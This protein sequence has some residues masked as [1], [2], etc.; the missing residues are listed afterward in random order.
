[1][2]RFNGAL[3]M[4]ALVVALGGVGN[5]GI[6]GLAFWIVGLGF[7]VEEGVAFF[8]AGFDG[9][10]DGSPLSAFVY[11]QPIESYSR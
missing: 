7:A 3:G 4:L 2:F 9:V 10:A 8:L 5:F 1:M 11:V 6:V